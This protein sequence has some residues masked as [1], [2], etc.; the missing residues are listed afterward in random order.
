VGRFVLRVFSAILSKRL[1]DVILLVGEVPL[2]IPA[3]VS[4]VA[5][6]GFDQLAL[7]HCG[8]PPR[9]ANGGSPPASR[10]LSGDWRPK[11][12]GHARRDIWPRAHE[13]DSVME[14]GQT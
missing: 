3:D 9:E 11:L 14:H 8:D 4:F 12:S 5:R 10:I 1:P 7:R 2:L 6:L 13:S